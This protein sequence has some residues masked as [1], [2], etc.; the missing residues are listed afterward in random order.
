MW[1]KL[2]TFH[3]RCNGSFVTL[4]F[5]C[6]VA[7]NCLVV[8]TPANAQSTNEIPLLSE[9]VI[10]GNEKTDRDLIL[11]EMGLQLGEPFSKQDMDDVWDLLEDIGYFAFVDMEYDDSEDHEVI[12]RIFLEEDITTLYRP[13]ILYSQRFKYELGAWVKENNLRGKGETLR[14]EAFA[15]RR[16]RGRLTWIK[17]WLFGVENLESSLAIGAEKANFVFRPTDYAKGEASLQIQKKFSYGLF[18]QVGVNQGF[19]EQ[20]EDYS[21]PLPDRGSDTSEISETST[22]FSANYLNHTSWLAAIGVDTRDNSFYPKHG[23]FGQTTVKYW[24]SSSFESYTETSFDARIFV[25]A[26]WNHVLA[27]R[28]WGRQTDNPTHLDN[29]LYFGGA[30]TIRGHQLAEL[31]GEEGYLLSAEYRVPLFMMPISHNGEMVGAGIHFFYDAG[32]AWFKGAE[33]GR[34]LQG[35]GAGIHLNVDKQQFR[36]EAAQAKDGQWQFEFFDLFNF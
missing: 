26:M 19:F 32:D 10:E 22:Y 17:P 7:A 20:K 36:F 30:N 21:W 29:L 3:E 11:K 4:L 23:I 34:S 9:I 6:I 18:A 2:P 1:L 31:E 27:L 28:G 14:L 13:S 33:A 24:T 8:P 15:Y 16:L 12:L 25:P 5:A 35:Y